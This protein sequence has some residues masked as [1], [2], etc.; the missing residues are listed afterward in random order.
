[1]SV[2]SRQSMPLAQQPSATAM[3]RLGGVSL[4]CERT[5]GGGVGGSWRSAPWP[6]ETL[7]LLQQAPPARLLLH[8]ADCCTL[9]ALTVLQ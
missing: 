5:K 1:M 3:L 2:G 6:P 8:W 9:T 7:R 4:A